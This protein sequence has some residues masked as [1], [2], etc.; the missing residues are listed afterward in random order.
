VTAC[1]PGPPGHGPGAAARPAAVSDAGWPSFGGTPDNTRYSPLRQVSAANVARLGVAWTRE[2]GFGQTTWESYPIVTGGTMY[3]TTST[4]AVWALD[5]ATGAMR[6]SYTP[7]PHVNFFGSTSGGATFPANRGVAVA[8]GM[9]YEL[10]F[11]CRLIALDA[12]TGKPRWQ[13]TVADPA[14]GYYETTAPATWD[15]LVFAGNSGG[16]SGAR[17]FIAAYDGQTGRPVWRTYTVPAPGHDWVPA[18]GRHGG[19]AVWM[20]PVVDTA[21]G[22]LYAATGNPSPDFVGEIRPGAD[23]DTD[24]IL[25]LDARTGRVTWF[26]SLVGHDVSDYDAASPPVL[27]RTVSAGNTV[28]AVGEAGK[29]GLFALLDPATGRP[30]HAP[31]RFVTIGTAAGVTCPGELGGSNYSPVGYDP[32]PRLAFVSGINYCG[33]YT[34]DA[35]TA[36]ATHPAGSPDLGGDVEPAQDTAAGTFTAIDVTTGMIRWQRAMPAPMLGGATVAGGLVFAGSVNGLLYGFD[37]STGAIRW[38]RDLGAGLGSAPVVYAIGG[39]EYLAVVSGGAAIAAI[40][41]LGP[42]GGRLYAFTLR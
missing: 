2:E 19:G 15:G 25:A 27:F 42:V 12:R 10:T 28:D 14:Q 32:G 23:P 29:S 13:V 5:A 18:T 3:L 33:D 30:L 34:R 7:A 41:H 40:D 9:V 17:G 11:D 21:T 31:A 4:N 26:T 8:G 35:P 39:R 6:W 36:V 1:G 24:G 20:P 22:I 37:T 38:Q 16:D